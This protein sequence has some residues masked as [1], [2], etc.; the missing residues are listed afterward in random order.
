[1]RR[2]TLAVWAAFAALFISTGASALT[3]EWKFDYGTTLIGSTPSE[4]AAQLCQLQGYSS[5]TGNDTPVCVDTQG[6][7]KWSADEYVS[8]I[9][10]GNNG[11]AQLQYRSVL[12]ADPCADKTGQTK[13]VET[14]IDPNDPSIADF[15]DIY[16]DGA[17]VGGC[18]AS[19]TSFDSCYTYLSG[20]KSGESYCSYVVTYTGTTSAGGETQAGEPTTSTD[21]KEET[22]IDAQSESTTETQTDYQSETCYTDGTNVSTCNSSKETITV[23]TGN[24]SVKASNGVYAQTTNYP[25]TVTVTETTETVTQPDG[26]SVQTVTT[27]TTITN[28][29]S[30]SFTGSA[31]GGSVSTTDQPGTTS[32]TSSKTTS[33]DAQG[34]V[35]SETT[36]EPTPDNVDEGDEG[37]LLAAGEGKAADWTDYDATVDS[38]GTHTDV[39]NLVNDNQ[40]SVDY[41]KNHFS[42]AGAA[43]PQSLFNFQFMG[44]QM[45]MD[46]C[47]FVEMARKLLYF[48]FAIM[49][50]TYIYYMWVNAFGK[51]RK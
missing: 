8:Y 29:G 30:S 49:T 9:Y 17:D 45:N 25:D 41:I 36:S 13:L 12:P 7:W 37:A 50:M 33:F 21:A 6:I 44:M 32:S 42:G 22:T 34:N 14:K 3:C 40:I 24:S 4:V 51:G 20:A 48:A 15:N 16:N 5:C 28:G 47:P 35:I 1:M 38:W 2:A 10:S 23:D 26:T 18:K 27:T 11:S 39:Q 43:C 19:Y 46:I 31:A